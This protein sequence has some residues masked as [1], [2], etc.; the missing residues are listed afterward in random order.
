VF[1][2]F[3]EVDPVYHE[4]H[5]EEWGKALHGD[6]A[7]FERLVLE[8]FQSGLS[9]VTILKKRP[10]FRQAFHDF[11][12]ERVAEYDESDVARLMQNEGIIRNRRKVEAA[13]TNAK[14]ARALHEK[15]LTLDDLIWSHVPASHV[16]P[17]S[18]D[19]VPTESEESRNLAKSLKSHGFVFVGPTTMYA[20]MQAIGMVNDHLEGCSYAS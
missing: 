18:W 14:A 16:R 19:E 11:S 10:A 13:I 2:C 12:I 4:Y 20:L 8:G 5:D 3:G 17:K 15:G 6:D 9:W 7:L 1:R